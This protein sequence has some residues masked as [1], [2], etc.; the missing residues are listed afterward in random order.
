MTSPA[1]TEPTPPG[2]APRLLGA[3]R[4]IGIWVTGALVALLLLASTVPIAAGQDRAA[5]IV[6]ILVSLAGGLSLRRPL[7]AGVVIGATFTIG[8]GHGP[9]HVG[10]ALF[11]SSI[12]V[13]ACAAQGRLVPAIGFATWH[14]IPPTLSSLLRGDDPEFFVSQVMTWFV[15]QTAAVLVGSWGR[16]LVQHAGAERDRR[17]SELAEQ[18]R[19]IARELHDT[20]VRAMTQVVMLSENAGRREGGSAADA[21]DLARISLTARRATEELRDLLDTLRVADEAGPS[22]GSRSVAGDLTPPEAPASCPPTLRGALVMLRQRLTREGFL[23][24]I[25][26]EGDEALPVPPAGALG[27]CLRE[28]EE[29]IVRHG[30][31]CEPVAVLAASGPAPGSGSE[32]GSGAASTVELAV[33]NGIEEHPGAELRGGDGLTGM[34]ERLEAIG[35]SLTT[36][37]EG[38]HFLTHLAAPCPTRPP[39]RLEAR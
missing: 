34:H 23:V 20:G 39:E 25:D 30:S 18:R 38:Q 1:T 4:E 8:L 14:L 10:S 36:R 15:L 21:E 22:D 17:I 12:A 35:G 28:I 2:T 11:A 13:G 27:R 7:L 26:I 24:R 16:A 31:R 5:V 19:A 37:R 33:R 6:A 32:A 9:L 29:N 3:P